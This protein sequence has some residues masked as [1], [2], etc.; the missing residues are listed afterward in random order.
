[1]I[2]TPD[3]ERFVKQMRRRAESGIW[4]GKGNSQY[5][6]D[7][8]ELHWKTGTSICFTRESGYHSGGWW[9]NPDYERC[10]HLSIAF[11][12]PILKKH[13]TFEPKEAQVWV[14]VFFG[15][16]HH[17]LWEESALGA[18]PSIKHELRHYR[19][20]CDLHWQPILPRGEV[21][22]KHFTEIGWKSFSELQPH[23][24]GGEQ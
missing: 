14:K 23:K 21:Y 3:I 16:N 1:M 2:I 17:L 18:N 12:D 11:F 7:C 4:N 13:R 19:L 9:K 24:D 10:Y 8:A 22:T 6:R 15:D 5:F 20:F